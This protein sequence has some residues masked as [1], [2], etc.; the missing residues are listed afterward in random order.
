MLQQV[1]F[2][3]RGHLFNGVATDVSLAPLDNLPSMLGKN[4]TKTLWI[5][6]VGN[7]QKGEMRVLVEE[8]CFD[9]KGSGRGKWG[10]KMIKIH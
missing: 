3:R 5:S 8:V 2:V 9:E 6:P 10:V 7:T 1:G 4:K